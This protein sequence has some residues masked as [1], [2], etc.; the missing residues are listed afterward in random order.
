MNTKTDEGLYE[1]ARKLFISKASIDEFAGWATPRQVDAVHRLLDT[2]LANRERAKHDRLLRR[3]RFPVVKGLDGY[4]FTNVRLPDGYML[5][6]LLG[7]GFIPRAQDLVFYGKTGRGKTHLAIGL[8]MKAIDMGL[9]VRFHQTAEL[10]LQLGKAKR[11]GTLE[12]MLR[13][14]GRAD[15]IILD[16]FGY[17]PFD[18]DGA[19][20]LYQIIA[21]SYERR[22]II[23]TTNIEFSKWGT[24]FRCRRLYIPEL[25]IGFDSAG[26]RR[27]ALG[28]E[29]NMAIPMPIVQD[30]RRLDRQGMSRAQIARRLHVD[31]GTVAKYADMEDC[32]PKPKADRRYG[33]KI[34]PYAHLVD[35]WL[36]ADRLLPRKQRHTIR[37]VHDRLLAETDYDGEYSTTMRYVHRWREANRGVPDR[38]GYV[39]LE[40]AAGSMQVDFG[41]ARARIAGEMADVHCLVVSLPYS[42]MRLCV[43]LPG[44]NAECLCHGLMLVFEHIGG[45]PP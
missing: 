12:T 42:N 39:R 27:P 40:W 20:L 18:I 1:K 25:P 35:E 7:L 41:V 2:E 29:R 44:E 33:S 43:A 31:R 5:D 11:D 10:V 32:S 13:D 9:G 6:E 36:E 28:K 8:G 23:F 30:I 14:I 21:G 17:V 19:R 37:R 38:E 22:S 45:V 24:V 15:L 4:D 26:C 16:E 3:A 34:D